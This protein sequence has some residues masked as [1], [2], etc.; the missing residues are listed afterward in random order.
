MILNQV[1]NGIAKLTQN[2]H[3]QKNDSSSDRMSIKS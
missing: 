3:Y 2:D 1:N